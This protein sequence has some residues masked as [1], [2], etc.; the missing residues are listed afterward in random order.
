MTT[1]LPILATTGEQTLLVYIPFKT[2]VSSTASNPSAFRWGSRS[3]AVDSTHVANMKGQFTGCIKRASYRATLGMTSAANMPD[4][5][6]EITVLRQTDEDDGITAALP[7]VET[8][9][10]YNYLIDKPVYVY[11]VTADDPQPSADTRIFMGYLQSANAI[12]ITPDSVTLTAT[13]RVLNDDRRI[14]REV[15][16]LENYPYMDPDKAG[17]RVPVVFGRFGATA[18]DTYQYEAPIIATGGDAN[19]QVYACVPWDD[20]IESIGN[21]R[22][23]DSGGTIKGGGAG[24][25]LTLIGVSNGRYS[26][27]GTDSDTFYAA[28]DAAYQDQAENYTWQPGDKILIS[29]I[30]G[31]ADGAG[32]V[33]TN[34]ALLIYYLLLDDTVGM[35]LTTA[36]LETSTFTAV[37]LLCTAYGFLAAARIDDDTTAW[38]FIQ[39]LCY[40][41]G[42][43]LVVVNGKYRLKFVG[44]ESQITPDWST[45]AAFLGFDSNGYTVSVDP[46]GER[47]KAVTLNYRPDFEGQNQAVYRTDDDDDDIVSQIA[48]IDG[49]YI[50]NDDTAAIV[51]LFYKASHRG[52]LRIIETSVDFNAFTIELAD[53][54]E[55]TDGDYAGIYRVT[56]ISRDELAATERIKLQAAVESSLV[57]R[58]G[59]EPGETIADSHMSQMNGTTMPT[60][61][62]DATDNQ[63]EYLAFMADDTSEI[64][65]DGTTEPKVIGD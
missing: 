11:R 8:I 19:I 10:R 50:R 54:I 65:P 15:L 1:A 32:D 24:D 63:R 48:E 3:Y 29:H 23:V 39:K 26:V 25:A 58:M 45:T 42:F 4:P 46:Q 57:A 27:Y 9:E 6:F 13:W 35:G 53:T 56:E 31:N 2:L 44:L 62:G 51:A 40:Q 60:D 47:C 41:F 33:V 18:I 28:I 59:Q 36:D 43:K 5:T 12:R 34:P 52:G 21:A 22:W 30:R 49:S 16:S 14:C 17:T 7:I 37:S 20:G 55:I 38:Q 61:F 64:S